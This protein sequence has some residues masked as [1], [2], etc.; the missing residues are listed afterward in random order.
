[1]L[2]RLYRDQVETG[3]RCLLPLMLRLVAICLVPSLSTV[4]FFL[5]FLGYGEALQKW[6]ALTTCRVYFYWQLAKCIC[7]DNLQSAFVLT[8]GKVY[9]YRLCWFCIVVVDDP[10]GFPSPMR[11]Y[12]TSWLNYKTILQRQ[13]SKNPL[14]NHTEYVLLFA[15][16]KK[17]H[18]FW[19]SIP[20][21]KPYTNAQ[22]LNAIWAIPNSW[23]HWKSISKP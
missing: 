4:R 21:Y 1:M 11:K 6:L 16:H 17:Q 12:S 14:R 23:I 3:I 10:G 22:T 9:L 5:T 15:R 7:T 18:K 2:L 20:R 19:T 13:T 8:P